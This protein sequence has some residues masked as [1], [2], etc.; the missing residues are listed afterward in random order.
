LIVEDFVVIRR[1]LDLD[2]G[3]L[4]TK[5]LALR[6]GRPNLVCLINACFVPPSRTTAAFS[7]P[8]SK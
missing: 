6:H 1:P 7:K 4:Q 5:L 8:Q 3:A 2:V